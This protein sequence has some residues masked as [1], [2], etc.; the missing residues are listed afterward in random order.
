[1]TGIAGGAIGWGVQLDFSRYMT[2]IGPVDAAARTVAVEPG[3]VLDDL[4]A[5]LAPHGLCFPADVATSSRAT[6]GGMIANNSCGSHSVYY[7]RTVDH[8]AALTCVLADGRVERWVHY[9]YSDLPPLPGGHPP[10]RATALPPPQQFPPRPDFAEADPLL[11]ALDEIRGASRD[12]VL[13]RY[14]RVLRRNGGYALDRL[15]LSQRAN[16][17]TVVIGSEGTLALVVGATLRLTPLPAHKALLVFH[18]SSVLDAIRATPTILPHRPAALELVDRLILSAGIS[19]AP[20]GACDAFL[21]GCP[22]AILICEL[23][24]DSRD[25]LER[26]LA[27]LDRE[28]KAQRIGQPARLVRDAAAQLAVWTLRNKGFG[29]LMSRPGDAHPYEFI[30]DAAIDPARLGDYIAELDAMLRAEGVSEIG[31]YAH[32]S[33]G[34]LHVRPTLNLKQ[35]ADVRKLRRI[36]ERTT[37]LVLRYGGAMT[38][39][40]GDG[41]VRSEWLERMY[42]PRIVGAF[43]ELKRAFDPENLLNPRKIVD[44]LPMDQRLRQAARRKSLPLATTFDYGP[45]RDMAGLA[46]MCSGV[47]ACRQKLVGAMCPSYMATLDERHSTRARAL[48]LRAA[49]HEDS[50]IVGLDDAALDEVMDL[51]LLCKACKTECPTGVDMARLKTDWLHLRHQKRGV[52]RASRFVAAAPRM[53]AFGSLAPRLANAVQ[54]SAWFRSLIERLFG[55]DSRIPPPLLAD[56]SFFHWHKDHFPK[57][58]GTRGLVVYFADTWTKYYWPSA[59]IAAVRLLEAAGYEVLVPRLACCGRPAIS[60]GLLDEAARLAKE[61]IDLLAPFAARGAWIVGSEPSCVSALI[62]EYPHLVRSDAARFVASR[63]RTTESLLAETL[64]ADP[65]ALP[66]RPDA[67]R[68]VLLH[69]HCHQKALWGTSNTLAMLNAATGGRAA[70]INSGCCGMAGSFGHEAAHYDVSRA[71]GSQRLFPAVQARGDAEV[72]VCGFSCREQIAHHA[73]VTPRHAL[74][75]AADCLA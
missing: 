31:Y 58:R 73:D 52:P 10:Q 1:G 63:V 62:D 47:G 34:V 5:A 43:G 7:G 53:A 6:L 50:L 67:G 41:I 69:G 68:R 14:P 17:A 44:P 13:A 74:E 49:L 71:V 75:I 2:R 54:Q 20:P 70:E 46:G 57:R 72:T 59:G 36:A 65:T 4:N 51:C 45:H 25:E 18:F 30:E 12:E 38:G 9:P 40:H 66:F 23:Y 26:R 21:D 60:K 55:F 64:A 15:C 3:V 27:A 37:E 29:L 32:A 11:I 8:V 42:G 28:A 22:P 24:D 56:Q 61:N 48:A 16:P 19:Q 33:V 35:P 39:E